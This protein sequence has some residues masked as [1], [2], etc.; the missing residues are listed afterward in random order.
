MSFDV[1]LFAI[2]GDSTVKRKTN[3]E[4]QTRQWIRK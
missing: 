2:G 3:Q 4:D 1:K